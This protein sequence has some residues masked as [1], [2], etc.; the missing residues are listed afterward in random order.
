MVVNT[1]ASGA[2]ADPEP[3]HATTDPGPPPDAPSEC[4]VVMKGGITSGVVYPKAL[5]V[6]SERYRFMNIGGASAGA[7]ASVIAAAAQYGDRRGS[8]NRLASLETLAE[9]ITQ[10]RFVEQLFQPYRI[11]RGPYRLLL[12]FVSDHH[13]LKWRIAELFARMLAQEWPVLVLAG[14]A[15]WAIWEYGYHGAGA[16]PAIVLIVLAVVVLAPVWP[17]LRVI[18]ALNAKRG[19]GLCSGKK[20]D[21]Y[22]TGAL[23]DWIHG[24]VQ[25]AA[26]RKVDD[27]PLTFA[28][29]F[30]RGI[31]LQLMTTDLSAGRPVRL[32]LAEPLSRAPG[33]RDYA[34]RP[35]ELEPLL[36][37]PLLDW[38][39]TPSVSPDIG[40]GYRQLPGMDLPVAVGARLS[41]S[42]PV[43]LSAVQL[44]ARLANRFEPRLF[45]DGGI[46]SN[47]PIHF[48]DGW[49]PTR[50]TFGLDLIGP[51]QTATT[52]VV[53][54]RGPFDPLPQ[55]WTAITGIKGFAQQIFDSARNWRDTLQMELP[56]FRER[57]C[58]IRL[59][60]QE[61]GLNLNMPPQTIAGLL[62]RGEEA[63]SAILADFSWSRQLWER[64][65]IL[66]ALL[67]RNLQ[68]IGAAPNWSLYQQLLG[69][70][71]FSQFDCTRDAD[72]A[73]RAAASSQ[74]GS[75]L[76]LADRWGQGAEVSLEVGDLP[77]PLPAMRITPDV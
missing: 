60:S 40:G 54:P 11:G 63:G 25:A 31:R 62:D 56:G 39:T 46:T 61:G 68:A 65:R 69:R 75:L 7:I 32:P 4:D 55:R 19:F 16:I 50:P 43:L 20:Q 53:M 58:H 1:G 72:K 37:S 51:D 47:F 73:W 66:A 59:S 34:F 38:L 10:P 35:D 26:G 67:E 74:V 15:S 12:S 33:D 41:L 14:G 8:D 23:L 64:F 3:S 29:L 49:L 28:D 13:P 5:W 36:P 27:P 9:T 52:N 70:D 44:H 30:E 42:F 57:V 76:D 6:L 45:S 22:K 17:I 21:G 18:V 48:F 24:E 2:V 71:D 77:A